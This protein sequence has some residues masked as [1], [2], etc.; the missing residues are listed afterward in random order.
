[1]SDYSPALQKLLELEGYW[2]LPSRGSESHEVWTNG[3]RSQTLPRHLSA[4]E[5]ANTILIQA[6]IKRRFRRE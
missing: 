3:E 2:L 4:H 6:G 5:L 1:M